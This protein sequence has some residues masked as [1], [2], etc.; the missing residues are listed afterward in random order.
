MQTQAVDAE[1]SIT[2]SVHLSSLLSLSYVVKLISLWTQQL[3]LFNHLPAI[4]SFLESSKWSAPC[5]SPVLSHQELIIH[6]RK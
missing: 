6:G 4:L 3:L 1:R 5:S 2:F